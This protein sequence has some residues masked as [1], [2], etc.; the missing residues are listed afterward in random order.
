[1]RAYCELAYY[2]LISDNVIRSLLKQISE[3][4]N[5]MQVSTTPEPAYYGDALCWL[6]GSSLPWVCDDGD[7]NVI[8]RYIL[9]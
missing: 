6:L 4:L 9:S 7:D 5:M 2:G 8:N 3:K 1:M